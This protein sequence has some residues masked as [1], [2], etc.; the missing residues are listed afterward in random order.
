MRRTIV[1]DLDG[2]L[3]YTL[4]DLKD[5]VNHALR[6]RG[7]AE[8]SLEEMR[9]FFGNGIRYAFQQAEPG[10]SEEE[11]E[12]LILLF[13]EYYSVHCMDR[14]RPYDGI[15]P[16]LVELKE[17]GYGMAIVSN[18]VDEAVK[19]LAKQFFGDYVTVAIGNRADI[20]RKPAPDSV[21]QALKELGVPKEDAVYVGDSEVDLATARAAGIPCVTVLWGFREKDFL[22]GQGA[23]LFAEH[24]QDVPGIL[25]SIS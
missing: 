20:R 4:E 23:D 14:T 7:Y 15:L 18:K 9:R 22:M 3:L 5:A 16:M 1:W 25:A 24:P 8:H 6:V 17:Q 10:A 2:T 21:L 12:E 19:E 11:L 13:K